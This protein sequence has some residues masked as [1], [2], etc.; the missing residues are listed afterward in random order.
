[1][2]P[3]FLLEGESV[4]T[5]P[6][7]EA[8][9]AI[10]FGTVTVGSRFT[11]EVFVANQG[12]ANLS[13][14]AENVDAIPAPFSLASGAF[15]LRPGTRRPIEF[16]IAPQEEGNF[17]VVVSF[18][19]NEKNAQKN[20]RLLGKATRSQ[21][22]C[23]PT[24][25]DL[26]HVVVGE[27]RSGTFTCT[28]HLDIPTTI[29]LGNMIGA[30]SSYF[31]AEFQSLGDGTT[32]ELP[33]GGSVDV[34]VTF[35]ADNITGP[36]SVN[37]PL[38]DPSNQQVENI[39]IEVHAVDYALQV[40]YE[41]EAG[42]RVP[43]TNCFRFP[44]TDIE[45]EE[46]GNLWVRNVSRN[47]VSITNIGLDP[48]S[49]H[50]G[51]LEPV[52]DEP[53]TV[54][55]DGEQEIELSIAFT[56]KSATNHKTNL[57][58]HGSGTRAAP[59]N[60]LRACLEGEGGGARI[61]CVPD[62]IDF[63]PVALGMSV[64]RSYKC[65]NSA[66]ERPDVPAQVLYVNG[67][68]T[69]DPARFEASV[70]GEIDNQGYYPG[71]EFI[72]DV[73][74]TPQ[75]ESFDVADVIIDNTSSANSRHETPVSG[76]GRDLPPC[77]FDIGPG[78]LR[79]GPVA[80]G[81]QRTLTAY[82]INQSETHECLINDLR[83]SD[84]SHPAFSVEPI[85]W[86]TIPPKPVDDGDPDNMTNDHRFPIEVTFAPTELGSFTGEVVFYISDPADPV[87]TIPVS[88]LGQKPCLDIDPQEVDFGAAPPDCAGREVFISVTNSCAQTI[89]IEDVV[90]DYDNFP[91]FVRYSMPKLP[92]EVKP[93]DRME[94]STYFRPDG[95]GL[96]QGHVEI[97]ATQE[98]D[99]G[100][101]EVV[102]P[103]RMMGE[104]KHDAIQTDSYTQKDRPK[105]DVLWVIDNSGSMGW[106]QTLLSTQIPTFMSFAIEQNVDFHIGVTTTG[107][108]YATSSGC[109]GGF[110]GNEDGRLFPHPSLGR[111]RIL[112]STMPR[113]QLL[114]TF[115]QNVMVGTCHASE[116]VYEAARRALSDPWINTPEAD[117]GNQGFLRR[118]ASLS[119]I[120]LT[121]END[122]D[123]RW[124]GDA[125]A[126]KSVTRYVDF[127]RSLKPS[128]MKDSVKVHMISGGMTS[129]S[130]AMACPRCVEGTELTNGVWIEIC[131]PVGDPSWD[132]AFLEMS[133][134]A[135]GFDTAFGLRGQ[136]ADVNGDGVIDQHD[137][138]VR[139]GGRIREATTHTGARVWHYNP[140]SNS[141]NFSPLYVPGS[142]QVIEVT[143]RVACVQY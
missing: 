122:V 49:D 84:D 56:P 97:V 47:P 60:G 38:M 82:V 127:F 114:D 95:T 59:L 140:E 107:V 26:G 10:D 106:A 69:T 87:Q 92:R 108:A 123:S 46:I 112:K 74:Y 111:P 19:T 103:V 62:R 121:D 25:L 115:A 77:V 117:G 9:Y 71:D 102:Y 80:P 45:M 137:L 119:I 63:G 21:L 40:L 70:R 27:S 110:N 37:L 83:L 32:A 98:E 3:K 53:L 68:T 22:V 129:C 7:G 125:S 35:H 134:G 15:D 66:I 85:E 2:A 139:V 73:T 132:D 36:A 33:S 90:F 13:V 42:E 67:V 24:R 11:P 128:R 61:S 96:F 58:I 12:N 143:Y 86:A 75:T 99:G 48:E 44:D 5:D 135:F 101:V 52:I 20:I 78:S 18:T 54:A 138:E 72:V 41:N 93:G 118:D 91:Q 29:T 23:T 81:G 100:P 50:F 39:V 1:L 8:H 136:P 88:G 4:I 116:A 43:L 28:N 76:T 79:F 34:E 133:E 57:V 109:P 104:G 30:H 113:D 17:D 51:Y 31:R 89:T 130:G 94:F 124:E 120:G 131:K 126:D 14:K 141:I 142:N 55:P 64:T 105:V 6:K 16:T 65:T